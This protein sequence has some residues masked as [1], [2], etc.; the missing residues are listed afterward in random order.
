MDKMVN[1]ILKRIKSILGFKTDIELSSYLEVTPQS[2]SK[3]KKRESLDYELLI[4]KLPD[5]IDL[6]WLFRG[7]NIDVIE[8]P[9]S[10]MQNVEYNPGFNW[11]DTQDHYGRAVSDYNKLYKEYERVISIVENYK[12]VHDILTDKI[13]TL[14][15]E[16]LKFKSQI[17]ILQ[18]TIMKMNAF[19]TQDEEELSEMSVKKVP[20]NN[21]EYK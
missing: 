13:E 18:E 16:N 9:I 20:E 4:N 17:D 11:K 2:I 14:K 1:D 6:N 10:K 19:Y 21:P 15:I 5:D 12:S 8:I 3:W 7:K